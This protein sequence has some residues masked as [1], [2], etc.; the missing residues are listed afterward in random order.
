MPFLQTQKEAFQNDQFVALLG[1]LG[2]QKPAEGMVNIM[3][4]YCTIFGISCRPILPRLKPSLP[5]LQGTYWRI[6]SN[7]TAAELRTRANILSGDDADA[8]NNENDDDFGPLQVSDSDDDGDNALSVVEDDQQTRKQRTDNLMYTGS[9]DDDAVRSPPK[10]KAA[11]KIAAKKM[12]IFDM[13]KSRDDNDGSA[14]ET[15]R[16][17]TSSG[18]L[19][20]CSKQRAAIIDSDGSD[21]EPDEVEVNTEEFSSQMIRK[22][23]AALEDSDSGESDRDDEMMSR[24]NN[25]TAKK[26]RNAIESDESDA[27][28]DKQPASS[29]PARPP[30]AAATV[31]PTQLNKR[32][33][34]GI[35]DDAGTDDDGALA[36][37]RPY[38]KPK[39]S[40]VDD[41]DGDTSD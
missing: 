39:L 15:L 8:A 31:S 27:E 16:S 28:S 20:G 29:P 24:A 35:E 3:E 23:L 34:A 32:Q 22:R 36:P 30:T 14:D 10:P 2:I 19:A 5:R 21:A 37:A 26:A 25:S 6:P 12:N 9:D 13:I 33:R 17:S 1:A 41:D 4:L 38:K 18:S 7:M 40:I 11:V